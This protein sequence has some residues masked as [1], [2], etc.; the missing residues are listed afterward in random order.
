MP[1]RE[2]FSLVRILPR[3]GIDY[4]YV[5]PKGLLGP[6]KSLDHAEPRHAHMVIKLSEAF[7]DRVAAF[8][9]DQRV[10][11]GV[12]LGV[13]GRLSA[14]LGSAELTEHFPHF[15]DCQIA[16]AMRSKSRSQSVEDLSEL[17][18]TEIF[19]E[20]PGDHP[21]PFVRDNGH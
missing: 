5:L 1:S 12:R 6:S 18:P 4:G 14:E 8:F 7:Q 20:G 11:F 10:E 13:F 15:R 9:Y 21:H 17:E 19:V 2:A 3:Y 16:R